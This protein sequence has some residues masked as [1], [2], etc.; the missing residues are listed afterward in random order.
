MLV[1]LADARI[2]LFC[3][4]VLLV[5]VALLAHLP[6]SCVMTTYV[7]LLP[8]EPAGLNFQFFVSK[9]HYFAVYFLARENILATL[10]L[11]QYHYN[12]S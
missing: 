12:V 9:P 1:C 6:V 5:V 4:I 2:R 7:A 8:A 11:E 3:D 10:P